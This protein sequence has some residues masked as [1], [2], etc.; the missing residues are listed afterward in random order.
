MRASSP[1]DATLISALAYAGLR[2]GEALALQ[3]RDIREQTILV[4]RAISLGEENETKTAAHRTVRLLLPLA[5]DLGEWPL[6]NGRP[7]KN[8]LIFSSAAGTP[9]TLAAYQSWRRRAFKPAIEAAGLGRPYDLRHSFASAH[10][11]ESGWF[12]DQIVPVELSGHDGVTPIDRDEHVRPDISIES[13]SRLRPVF[14]VDGTVTPGNASGMNDA[15]AA[16]VLMSERRASELGAPARA[17]SVAYGSCGV[18]P[19]YMGIG[20][21]PAVRRVLERAGRRLDE[22]ELIELNEAFA[23]QALSVIDALGLDESRVNPNGGA[24][25]LGHPLGATGAI[26]TTKLLAEMERRDLHLGLVTLCIGGGQ[27]IAVL[28]ER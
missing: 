17:R 18:D 19:A 22:V 8:T 28:L 27:G 13:L 5:V 20:P 6:R 7:G 3:W 26:L 12:S 15:S 10:A 11:V 14:E 16:L 25:A 23:A 1:R 4:E 9:W 2:P 21:V 24:I